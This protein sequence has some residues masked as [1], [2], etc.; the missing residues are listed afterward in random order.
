MS[1]Q[2]F[3]IHVYGQCTVKEYYS[4]NSRGRSNIIHQIIEE[5]RQDVG[6]K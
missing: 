6:P 4:S 3:K 5:E 1:V 2:K